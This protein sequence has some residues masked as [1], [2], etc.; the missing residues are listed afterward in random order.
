[1]VEAMACGTPVLAMPGGSVPE[2]VRD[3]VSGYVCRTVRDMV[4]HVQTLDIN[5]HA[6][7]RYVE[8]N[9][10]IERMVRSYL[11]LYEE[12][13]GNAGSRQVA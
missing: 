9:F 3:G 7:R 13:L 2:V 8:E 5:P 11:T 1:M 10:S 4:R 6:V 12:A